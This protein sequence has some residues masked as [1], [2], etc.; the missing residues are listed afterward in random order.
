MFGS[1]NIHDIYNINYIGLDKNL[2]T[3]SEIVHEK[4]NY[5]QVCETGCKLT[6]R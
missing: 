5:P 6:L 2:V 3:L 4:R 1:I